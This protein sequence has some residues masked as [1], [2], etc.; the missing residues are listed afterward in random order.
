VPGGASMDVGLAG[1]GAEACHC[2]SQVCSDCSSWAKKEITRPTR[3]IQIEWSVAMTAQLDWTITTAPCSILRV[4]QAWKS[5]NAE[6]RTSR[7]LIW[8]ELVNGM[9][10]EGSS[11]CQLLEFSLTFLRYTTLFSVVLAVAPLRFFSFLGSTWRDNVLLLPRG[12]LK[13]PPILAR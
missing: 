12:S 10:G 2:W 9:L 8:R 6:Y 5:L 7:Q 1:C 11:S 13:A 3:T 4:A